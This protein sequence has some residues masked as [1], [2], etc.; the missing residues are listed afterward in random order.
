M[1]ERSFEM[2]S[3]KRGFLIYQKPLKTTVLSAVILGLLSLPATT[4]TDT[5]TV[6]S[7]EDWDR[8]LEMLRSTPY[9]AFSEEPVKKRQ[10]G[11]VLYDPGKA[12]DGYF[13]YNTR[14]SG[15][16]FLLDIS[17]QVVHFWTYSPARKG[18][19][20]LETQ[21]GD[22]AVLLENGDLLILSKFLELLRIDWNSRLLWKKELHSHHD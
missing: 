1:V 4:A 10:A 21:F 18:D 17:G 8:R 14:S 9:I 20:A 12:C 5:T 3:N 22:H 7:T 16:V 6:S 13:L 19:S 15:E 11:V 2:H